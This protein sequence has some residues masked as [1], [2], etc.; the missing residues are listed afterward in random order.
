MNTFTLRK[1]AAGGLRDHLGGGVLR[2][3]VDRYWHVPH[4]EKMLYDQAQLAIAYLD[5]FQIT[6]DPQFESVT[7]DIL[8]YVA[9]DMTSK[10]GGFFSAE[11]AD[12]PVPVAAVYDR[13]TSESEKR[14]SIES[15]AAHRTPLQK[16]E[17]SA[18]ALNIC[19]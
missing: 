19:P 14:A 17:I 12:S 6:R 2:Y 11:D 7:R 18:G 1:V 15:S 13:R 10:E 8:D 4:F 5:A 9:R 16:S 3:S